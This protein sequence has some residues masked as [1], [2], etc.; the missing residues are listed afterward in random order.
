MRKLTCFLALLLFWPFAL[1]SQS[2]HMKTLMPNED[3]KCIARDGNGSLWVGTASGISVINNGY[4]K[5]YTQIRLDGDETPLYEVNRISIVRGYVV[6]GSTRGMY[7]YDADACRYSPLMYKDLSVVADAICSH[8]DD[9]YMFS[10]DVD[11]LFKYSAGAGELELVWDF[12]GLSNYS[13]GGIAIDPADSGRIFLA[14][15]EKGVFL[16]DPAAE[17]ISRIKAIEGDIVSSSVRIYRNLLIVPFANDGLKCYRLDEGFALE[18][19][20][21]SGPGGVLSSNVVTSFDICEDD[22]TA[23]I[24]TDGRGMNIVSLRTGELIDRLENPLMRSVSKVILDSGK[25]MFCV[26][27][28][29]GVVNVYVDFLNVISRQSDHPNSA[30]S[31][32]KVLS[33]LPQPDGSVWLGTDGGG[34]N[35]YKQGF[36]FDFVRKYPSTEPLKI[37]SIAVYDDNRLILSTRYSGFWLFDRKTEDL[38][39]FSFPFYGSDALAAKAASE[40]VY[41]ERLND[42][43]LLVVSGVGKCFKYFIATG[44]WEEVDIFPQNSSERVMQIHNSRYHTLVQTSRSIY[45]INNRSLNV[46]CLYENPEN[47]DCSHLCSD[48]SIFYAVRNALYRFSPSKNENKQVYTLPDE[49]AHIRGICRYDDGSVWMTASN[50]NLYCV[51][52]RQDERRVF[53]YELLSDAPSMFNQNFAEQAGELLL[54]SGTTGTLVVNPL[55]RDLYGFA[56]N[57]EV[58]PVLAEDRNVRIPLAGKCQKRPHKANRWERMRLY[59][60]ICTSNPMRSISYDV[61][62]YKRSEKV[63]HAHQVEPFLE[64]PNMGYGRYNVVLTPNLVNGGGV[65]VEILSFKIGN[66]A[67]SAWYTILSY[68]LLVLIVYLVV[69]YFTRKMRAEKVERVRLE[70]RESKAGEKVTRMAN[71]AHDLR[72]PISIVFNRINSALDALK[73][74]PKAHDKLEAALPQIDKMTQMVNTILNIQS[75]ET[76]DEQLNL[77]LVRLNEWVARSVNSY[78]SV[79]GE[80][81]MSI[82]YVPD[83]SIDKAGIDEVKIEDCLHN[84]VTNAIKYGATGVI[85]V[86]TRHIERRVRVSVQDQGKG[87]SSSPEELF[88][89][90]YREKANADK[91][92]GYGLGLAYVKD[93]MVKLGGNVGAF[94]NEDGGATF[95]FEFPLNEP[96]SEGG[97][98]NVEFTTTECTILVVDD[99]KDINEFF[100]SEYQHMFRDIYTASNGHRALDMIRALRPDIILSDIQMPGMDG[101]RLCSRVKCDMEMSH[102]PVI[103]FTSHTEAAAKDV[104]PK[105]GPDMVLSRPFDSSEVYRAIKQQLKSRQSLRDRFASGEIHRLSSRDAFSKGDEDFIFKVNSYLDSHNP[106][107]I[108]LKDM[109]AH[110]EMTI[111][112]L[113]FKMKVIS[114]VSGT[115]FIHA[116]Y[117]E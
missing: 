91:T 89:K 79:C 115:A 67:L 64:L 101:F 95:W 57:A 107:E 81:G 53:V 85:T 70:F 59:F 47:M 61:D 100:I 6:F 46:R 75:M 15:D 7:V 8:N 76:L 24:A 98:A 20:F 30:L 18:K 42:N 102:I 80:K 104:Q 97:T 32:S 17:S 73:D 78:Q 83:I 56:E 72:T 77:T 2:L 96:I 48:G 26:T 71:L 43:S 49:A 66:T 108:S 82:Q 13:F 60:S 51:A 45:E 1:L 44:K 113:D 40:G 19:H 27:P 41:L 87:F 52:G 111:Q 28:G 103:L 37:V 50:G 3:I 34:L 39:R 86:S 84:M 21:H 68:A 55:M 114:G 94:N 11:C 22:E 116:F 36:P 38:S 90:G 25:C 117:N 65:P 63:F 54:F 10:R 35:L 92:V 69:F 74:N 106:E 112:M 4:V 93:L 23:A 14:D 58:V 12:G 31:N 29:N 88:S 105:T 62:I 109:A 9:V 99:E 16:L 33:V 110:L 5:N